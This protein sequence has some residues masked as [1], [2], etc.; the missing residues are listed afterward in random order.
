MNEIKNI[1]ATKK[2]CKT[3]KQTLFF[4]KV[5]KWQTF[6]SSDQEKKKKKFQITKIRD[7]HQQ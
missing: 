2:I 5:K 1:K 7:G 3:N 6:T 4:R